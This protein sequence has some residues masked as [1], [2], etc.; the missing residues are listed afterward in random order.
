MACCTMI[1]WVISS[2]RIIPR[3]PTNFN[4]DNN[5]KTTLRT[6]VFAMLLGGAITN[7]SASAV[8]TDVTASGAGLGSFSVDDSGV[9]IDGNFLDLSKTFSSVN[10]I[11]L[12]FTVAHSEATGT[13]YNVNEVIKNDTPS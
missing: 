1:M 13:P 9:A 12:T 10:P 7:A 11:T 5:M 2:S 3:S 4:R 8:I 6:L